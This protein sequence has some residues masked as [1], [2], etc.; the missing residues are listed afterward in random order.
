MHIKETAKIHRNIDEN[1]FLHYSAKLWKTTNVC[2]LGLEWNLNNYLDTSLT[3]DELEKTL[4]L[5]ENG[6]S[7]GEDNINSDSYKYGPEEFKLTLL[8]FLNNLYTNS[9]EVLT[10]SY[11]TLHRRI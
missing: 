10:I 6:R 9:C 1:I 11:N 8:Q 7:P 5:M 2:E 3:L 4:K